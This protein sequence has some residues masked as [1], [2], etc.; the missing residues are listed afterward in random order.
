M[1]RAQVPATVRRLR[2]QPKAFLT[3]TAAYEYLLSIIRRHVI[4][5]KYVLDKNMLVL[6]ALGPDKRMVRMAIEA[7]FKT[8]VLKVTTSV[9]KP[10]VKHFRGQRGMTSKYSRVYIRTKVPVDL[11][12]LEVEGVAK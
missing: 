12:A 5:E 11:K 9:R 8:E 1:S 10:Y 3:E 2:G 4:S 7:I 6:D